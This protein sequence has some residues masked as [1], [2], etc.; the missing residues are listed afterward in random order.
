MVHPRGHSVRKALTSDLF[1]ILVLVLIAAFFRFHR[2][3]EWPIGLWRDEAAN[4]LEALRVLD[5]DRAIFFGT[6]EPMFIYLV[7]ASIAM[8][9]R[10]PLAIRA[11]AAAAGTATIPITYLLVREVLR[12]THPSERLVAVLTS[13]WMATSYWHLNFSRLGFRGVLL[14]LFAALSFCFLWRGWNQL[15]ELPQRRWRYA[16]FALSGACLAL[17]LYTYTPSRFLL[18]LLIPFV[19]QAV[20]WASSWRKGAVK[21]ATAHSSAIAPFAVFALCFALAFAPLCSHF[22]TEPKSLFVRS[23]VTVFGTDSGE[24]LSLLITRNLLRQLGMF[25]LLAD[26][27]TRH[28]PA[29]RPAFDLAT[30]GLFV[31][32]FLLSL[33]RWRKTPYLFHANARHLDLPRAATLPAGYRCPAHSLRIP[34]PGSGGKLGMVASQG[35]VPPGTMGHCG[36]PRLVSS[37]LRRS[38]LS[39]LL[40]SKRG[41]DR[42]G[43][44]L[45]SPLRGDSLYNE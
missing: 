10:N 33:R 28:N 38:L 12:S 35:L 31:F 13:L 26:P 20:S 22:L 1:I 16:W 4:G 30:L 34:C 27:N 7:A 25:G 36:R 17:T 44:G 14:P 29:G 3:Q 32:G 37:A 42:A 43:Q 9:G 19:A 39:R 2:L 45:R 41:R 23:G 40:R 6:R 24:P 21:A 5:G 8:L 18:L 11:A 15:E